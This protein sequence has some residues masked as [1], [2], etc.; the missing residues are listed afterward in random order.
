VNGVVFSTQAIADLVHAV[1]QIVAI[2]VEDPPT[3]Q[4]T[5]QM[6]DMIPDRVTIVG[7]LGGVYLLDEDR[8]CLSRGAGRNCPGVDEW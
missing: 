4:R 7:G 6:L 8:L 1:P 5:A 3:P 2:K